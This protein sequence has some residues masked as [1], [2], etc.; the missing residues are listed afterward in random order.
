[1]S[2]S[3]DGGRVWFVRVHWEKEQESVTLE[4]CDLKGGSRTVVLSD[5]SARAF[6]LLPQGLIYAAVE[7]PQN[8]TNLWEVPV[9]PAAEIGRA[10]V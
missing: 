8:L 7:G 2:W 5:A 3:P 9:S 1:M 10:H 6:R 4:T